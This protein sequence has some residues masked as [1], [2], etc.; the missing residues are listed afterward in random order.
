MSLGQPHS[1]LIAHSDD[2]LTADTGSTLSRVCWSAPSGRSQFP[3][4]LAQPRFYGL[5]FA[6][7]PAVLIPR[8]ETEM[9]V[10]YVLRWVGTRQQLH[11]VDV[12]TGSGCIAVTL[13]RHLPQ[14]ELV[15][16]D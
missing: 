15:A 11:I 16:T 12:G 14:A 2:P 9:M 7:S 4:W 3:I 8:P 5:D 10:D 1:Y 13:A 6:V